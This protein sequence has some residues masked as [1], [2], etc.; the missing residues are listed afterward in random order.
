MA[1]TTTSDVQKLRE[2]IENM[3][4]LSQDAFSEIAAIASLALSRFETPNGYLSS[5][6]IVYA[7]RAIRSTAQSTENSINCEA[8]QVGCNHTD[9]AMVRRFEARR[10]AEAM[11]CAPEVSQ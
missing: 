3:D 6:D 5:E 9:A 1:K 4:G 2:A 10:A 11:R 8:E 7:L